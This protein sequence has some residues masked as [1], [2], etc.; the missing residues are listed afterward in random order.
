LPD[1]KV[2]PLIAIAAFAADDS[3]VRPAAVEGRAAVV[4]LG[5]TVDPPGV[6]VEE[7][8]EPPEFAVP[9][10]AMPE[11]DTGVVPHETGA[12]PLLPKPLFRG[13]APVPALPEP[14]LGDGPIGWGGPIGTGLPPTPVTVAPPFAGMPIV[15][16]AEGGGGGGTDVGVDGPLLRTA[17]RARL[18]I[19][20]VMDD[21]YSSRPIGTEIEHHSATCSINDSP[22]DS[23][24][25]RR[26][27]RCGARVLAT[28]CAD[29]TE[30]TVGRTGPT[31]DR[32]SVRVLYA[33]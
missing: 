9:D 20:P 22:L 25:G 18:E 33:S 10:C 19:R 14:G 3:A 32:S 15:T 16:L 1:P 6:F 31:R 8:A 5:A 13:W 7:L 30:M 27:Q 28:V 2:S 21:D 11:F 17:T 23:A 29:G 24:R 12:S 26:P 4:G